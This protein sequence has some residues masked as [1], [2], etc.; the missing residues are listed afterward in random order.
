MPQAHVQ[1]PD[2]PLQRIVEG[3]FPLRPGTTVSHPQG[4]TFDV[5]P[6]GGAY[7]NKSGLEQL[8]LR[9]EEHNWWAD[10]VGEQ[11]S[12]YNKRVDDNNARAN[13]GMVPDTPKSGWRVWEWA[14][15]ATSR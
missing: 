6:G 9:E 11:V 15:R 3:V 10:G 8:R 7:L 14:T 4:K 13:E 2:R 5:G 1:I 12:R